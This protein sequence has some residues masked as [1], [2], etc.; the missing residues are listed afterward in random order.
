LTIDTPITA[1]QIYNPKSEGWSRKFKASLEERSC[2]EI[3]NQKED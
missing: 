2:L 1:A 3:K